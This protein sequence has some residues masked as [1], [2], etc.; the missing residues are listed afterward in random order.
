MRFCN[1]LFALLAMNA[2]DILYPAVLPQATAQ[3]CITGLKEERWCHHCIN[4]AYN[5]SLMHSL[6]SQHEVPGSL[7]VLWQLRQLLEE[8]TKLQEGPH[9]QQ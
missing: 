9:L 1:S 2:L 3:R 5:T 8:A 4:M 7:R 6:Q